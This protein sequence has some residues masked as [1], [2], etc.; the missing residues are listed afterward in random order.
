MAHPHMEQE[1]PA[2]D[3]E[4]GGDVRQEKLELSKETEWMNGRLVYVR[5]ETRASN[6]AK[7]NIISSESQ[8][9]ELTDSLVGS[10]LARRAMTDVDIEAEIREFRELEA[11]GQQADAPPASAD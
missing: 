6:V 4:T 5:P 1:S 2:A 11:E 8:R 10:V 9:E 3:V 7:R